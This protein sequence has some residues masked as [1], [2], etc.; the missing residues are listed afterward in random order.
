MRFFINE[1]AKIKT[2]APAVNSPTS[3][4]EDKV[5]FNSFQNTVSLDITYSFIETCNIETL[6]S[7]PNT[8][9]CLYKL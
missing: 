2:L 1:K 3:D 7:I 6:K 5:L 8:V 9:T 4:W